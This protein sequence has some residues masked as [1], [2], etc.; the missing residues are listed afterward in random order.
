MSE[1]YE[2]QILFG[3]YQMTLMIYVKRIALSAINVPNS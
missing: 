2:Y 1:K 3:V